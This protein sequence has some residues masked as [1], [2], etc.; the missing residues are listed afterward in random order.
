M[1]PPCVC[2][3]IVMSC[4]PAGDAGDL[5]LRLKE[6]LARLGWLE[7]RTRSYY[8]ARAAQRRRALRL[9]RHVDPST[10]SVQVHLELLADNAAAGREAEEMLKTGC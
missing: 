5:N 2:G 9:C 7:R 6:E 8:F 3:I 10:P 4:L 1:K